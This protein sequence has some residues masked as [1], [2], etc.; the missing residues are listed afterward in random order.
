MNKQDEI[1]IGLETHVQL[2]TKSKLFCGC[3][4]KLI[5]VEEDNPNSR[6]CEICLGHPGSK[7]MLNQKAIDFAL[8]LCLALGCKIEPK[9]FFSRKTYFYPDMA[10]NFQIT[11]YEI[12]LGKK[13]FIKLK[14]GT[15]VRIERIHLEEDPA[16]L[17]HEKSITESNHVLI[18][19]NRAGIPLCEI[20]TTPCMKNPAQAREFL[21]ELVRI[22]K[23]LDIFDEETCILK[24]DANVN[25]IGHPRI[26]VKNITGFK[27]I[28]KAMN[29]EIKR[30]KM[31]LKK[32]NLS[33]SK[34]Q[35]L[36]QSTMAWDADTKSTKLLRTKETEED[37]GFIFDADLVKTEILDEMIQIIRKNIPE[38]AHIRTE[39]YSKQ[40]G[41]DEVDAEVLSAEI[42]VAELFEKV[43]KE[44]DAKLAAKWLRRELLRVLNY[45]KKSLKDIEMDENHVIELL[46][47]VENKEITETSAQKIMEL[48]VEKSFSPKKY[49]EENKLVVISDKSKL[50]KVCKDVIKENKK[51]VDDY[52]A[53]NEKAFRF[54][55]GQVM[56]QTKNMADPK[57]V[58]EILKKLIGGKS[59]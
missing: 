19:Y 10:K 53:G 21:K 41:V 11:Q 43:A 38:L 36:K 7:P 27:E 35:E 16:A 55:I 5:S 32:M 23:Y 52:L 34:K 58:N 49:A 56:K 31:V 42:E 50:E 25:I 22:I 17:V 37:Y 30:Q 20:V 39:R 57:T 14:D 33:K 13:G 18:D 4:T 47:M 2:N 51:V 9:I 26:E 12:P 59:K 54:L 8:K 3:S 15:I 1:M 40:L 29:Y 48:L 24:T 46:K 44:V 6:C 45:N 28:E